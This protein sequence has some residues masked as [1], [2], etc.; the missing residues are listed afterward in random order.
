[1]GEGRAGDA[2]EQ[3]RV[4]VGA[5]FGGVAYVPKNALGGGRGIGGEVGWG[6]VGRALIR[7]PAGPDVISSLVV[8]PGD[9]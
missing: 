2:R 6:G 1:M 5:G 3:G 7:G 9:G 4:G 8:S